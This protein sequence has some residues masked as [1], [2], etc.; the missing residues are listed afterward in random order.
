MADLTDVPKT[1]VEIDEFSQSI[2]ELFDRLQD[3][4]ETLE[5]R[6]KALENA[7]QH[8]QKEQTALWAQVRKAQHRETQLLETIQSLSDRLDQCESCLPRS[9]SVKA[10]TDEADVLEDN[11]FTMMERR[12]EQLE[13]KQLRPNAIDRVVM[14]SMQRLAIETIPKLLESHLATPIA[15]A[16]ELVISQ[17]KLEFDDLSAKVKADTRAWQKTLTENASEELDHLTRRLAAVR[18][19]LARLEGK[20]ADKLF[21]SDQV[22]QS[23]ACPPPECERRRA[24]LV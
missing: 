7:L 16:Q 4:G 19:E 3:S 17:S 18:D 23:A 14:D 20:K 11:W 1:A 12:L 6:V 5:R 24:N 2:G 13:Q 21:V 10:S 9:G 15:H 22:C 8:S